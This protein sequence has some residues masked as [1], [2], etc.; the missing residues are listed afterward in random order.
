MHKKDSRY[1]FQAVAGLFCA[2]LYNFY[3]EY[4]NFYYE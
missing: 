3:A 2:F 1:G 4:R